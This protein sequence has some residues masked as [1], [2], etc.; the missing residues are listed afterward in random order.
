MECELVLSPEQI[1]LELDAG[2]KEALIQIKEMLGETGFLASL[3]SATHVLSWVDRDVGL[4][5]VGTED[6]FRHTRQGTR[7]QERFWANFN[8]IVTRKLKGIC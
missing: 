4:V 6:W 7:E 2:D 5:T 8:S 3:F 1:S